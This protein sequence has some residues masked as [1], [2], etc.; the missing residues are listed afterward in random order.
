MITDYID[1]GDKIIS[2]QLLLKYLCMYQKKK[3]KKFLLSGKGDRLGIEHILLKAVP[4]NT[5][6]LSQTIGDKDL[7]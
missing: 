3:K 2:D 5:N 7:E 1:G 4:A 6:K